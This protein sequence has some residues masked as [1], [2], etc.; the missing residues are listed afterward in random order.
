MALEF[1]GL[2]PCNLQVQAPSLSK[3]NGDVLEVGDVKADVRNLQ[4]AIQDGKVRS[5]ILRS[6]SL[7]QVLG[8]RRSSLRCYLQE[9]RQVHLEEMPLEQVSDSQSAGGCFS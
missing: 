9:L 7:I 6:K 5:C 3:R 4:T 1:K 8:L 2:E